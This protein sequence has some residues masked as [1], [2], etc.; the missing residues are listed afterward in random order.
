MEEGEKTCR[1]KARSR[2][3]LRLVYFALQTTFKYNAIKPSDYAAM[4]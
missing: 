2:A 4:R 1:L 3:L